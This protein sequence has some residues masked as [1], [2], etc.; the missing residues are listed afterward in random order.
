[1]KRPDVV[2]ELVLAGNQSVVGVKI[3]GDNYEINVLLSADDVDRLNREELPV[4]PD[5]HAVTAGTC[6]N[7][8][9]HWSRCDGNVMTIV[10]GQDD[11]TWDF[12]VWMPVDTF[13]EIKRLIL[14]L[15]PSL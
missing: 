3:Q 1:M 6:F 13:T 5:E 4:A 7:A 8:P 9:T 2:A 11:V 12:G 14:A 15:R 10:V